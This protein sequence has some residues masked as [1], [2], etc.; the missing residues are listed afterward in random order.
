MGKPIMVYNRETGSLESEIVLGEGW[1]RLLYENRL[2]GLVANILLKRRAFSRLYGRLQDRS[3]SAAK[4]RRF[5]ADLG[6]DLSEAEKPVEDYQCFNDFFSRALKKEARPI[7]HSPGIVISPCDARLLVLPDL[8]MKAPI[9]VKGGCFDLAA[10]LDDAALA[11]EYHGGTL[12]LYRLCPVDYH[13]FHFP[14]RCV[15][16]FPT[17]LNGDLH[18]VNPI[19]LAAGM[20]ILDANLRHRTLLDTDSGLGRVAMVEIGAMCVGSVKQTF[21]PNVPAERGDEKGMFRFGGSTVAVLYMP[22][23]V[24]ADQDILEQSGRD[25]ET[26]VKL[27]MTVGRRL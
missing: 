12:F 22:G 21:V 16:G 3:A 14:E 7:D 8:D 2:G 27:G 26:L 13:R 10:L 6:I 17:A 19:A 11:E 24:E 9:R 20:K 15:P 4:I 23:K 18:S 5:A 25:L 1:I